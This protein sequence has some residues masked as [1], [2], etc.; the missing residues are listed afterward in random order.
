MVCV[1]VEERVY[2]MDLILWP[3]TDDKILL[4]TVTRGESM[5][6]APS[7]TSILS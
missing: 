5:P 6:S 7:I 3:E 2:G 4:E 1:D